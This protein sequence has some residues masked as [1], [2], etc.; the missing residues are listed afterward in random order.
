[1]CPREP[2]RQQL[3]FDMSYAIFWNF[4]FFPDFFRNFSGIFLELSGIREF[5]CV[6]V[7]QLAKS[8]NLIGHLHFSDFSG[9]SGFFPEFSGISGQ[10]PSERDPGV[11]PDPTVPHMGS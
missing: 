3:S 7:N 11:S 6:H 1:M 4:R 8:F 2:V 5:P 9:F 10:R